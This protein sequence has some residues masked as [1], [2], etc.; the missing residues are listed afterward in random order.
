MTTLNSLIGKPMVEIMRARTKVIVSN[1]LR[2]GDLLPQ[3][4]GAIQGEV[5]NNMLLLLQDVKYERAPDRVWSIDRGEKVIGNV[6][7]G[8]TVYQMLH[9]EVVR[10]DHIRTVRLRVERALDDKLRE[11]NPPAVDE[12]LKE[13]TPRRID[14]EFMALI[15]QFECR[16]NTETEQYQ[17][18][19]AK[20][21]TWGGKC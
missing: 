11:G 7:T 2:I 6:L 18:Y 4:I 17:W 8:L 9:D 14:Q 5:W 12:R 10:H 21:E 15:N 16:F 13:R 1:A 19:D 20:N 3:T